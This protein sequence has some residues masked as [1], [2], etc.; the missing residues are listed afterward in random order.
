MLPQRTFAPPETVTPFRQTHAAPDDV[1]LTV[2]DLGLRFGH[3]KALDG[4]SLEIRRGAVVCV[5]VEDVATCEGPS[6]LALHMQ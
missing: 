6:T 5:F 1:A 2:Q 3:I 4:V